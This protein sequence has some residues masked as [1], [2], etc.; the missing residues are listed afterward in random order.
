[1]TEAWPDAC[2]RA[3]LTEAAKNLRARGRA[4]L[5]AQVERIRS[6]VLS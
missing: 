1:M 5:A 6:E 3:D 2:L 4:D